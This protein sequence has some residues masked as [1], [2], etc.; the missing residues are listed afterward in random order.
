MK[1]QMG[2]RL[3][4]SDI[5]S[6]RKSFSDLSNPLTPIDRKGRTFPYKMNLMPMTPP[7]GMLQTNTISIFQRLSKSKSTN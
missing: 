1:V 7:P 2:P 4:D 3:N 6:R 5:S